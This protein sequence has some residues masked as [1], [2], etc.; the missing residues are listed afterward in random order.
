MKVRDAYERALALINERDSSGDYHDDVMDYEKN[1]PELVN[2]IVTLLWLD[3]SIIRKVDVR[4]MGWDFEPMTTMDD[5]IPLH[6]SLASGVLP[7]ALASFMLLEEDSARAEYFYKLF[8]M[9]RADVTR[10]FA[11]AS[12]EKIRNIYQ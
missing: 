7:L 6:Q 4:N 9:A 5:E 2:S 12:H 3:E 11:S 10:A 8:S 1:A